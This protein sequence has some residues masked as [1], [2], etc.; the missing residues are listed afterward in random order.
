MIHLFLA[1]IALARPAHPTLSQSEH[2]FIEAVVSERTDPVPWTSIFGKASPSADPATSRQLDYTSL[3]G[4]DRIPFEVCDRFHPVSKGWG[5]DC[6]TGRSG[7]QAE[8]INLFSEALAS[9]LTDDLAN[10]TKTGWVNDP[11][12]AY[13]GQV[14]Q[15]FTFIDKNCDQIM[16]SRGNAQAKLLRDQYAWVSVTVWNSPNTS[17]VLPH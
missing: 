9:R 13:F 11:D 10:W 2:N 8:S 15:R 7:K 16:I 4:D 14:R 17:C 3:I 12:G 1:A 6:R 5:M